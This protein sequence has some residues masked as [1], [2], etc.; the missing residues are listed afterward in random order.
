M[1]SVKQQFMADVASVINCLTDFKNDLQRT[2]ALIMS[3]HTVHSAATNGMLACLSQIN[4]VVM[5][6]DRSWS[7]NVSRQIFWGRCRS[8]SWSWSWSFRSWPWSCNGPSGLGLGLAPWLVRSWSWQMRSWSHHCKLTLS[9][10]MVPI[11]I[12]ALW[13]NANTGNELRFKK[14]ARGNENVICH[15]V[16]SITDSQAG[17]TERF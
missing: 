3:P 9:F 5:S 10:P 2:I 1:W 15:I 4:S 11:G 13:E 17:A 16:L 14:F 8:W 6:R 12:C 7:R